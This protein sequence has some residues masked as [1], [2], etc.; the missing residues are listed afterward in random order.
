MEP[1]GAGWV[2][3]SVPSGP[4]PL[5]GALFLQQIGPF[6]LEGIITLGGGE[7]QP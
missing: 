6:A 4:S 1:A 5:P 2:W 3:V 7:A